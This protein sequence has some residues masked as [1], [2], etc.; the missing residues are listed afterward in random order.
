MEY[1]I[2]L[3]R[4]ESVGNSYWNYCTDANSDYIC[5]ET[6][7]AMNDW[8]GATGKELLNTTYLNSLDSTSKSMIGNA[9]YYLGGLGFESYDFQGMIK[10][11][12][13]TG[14]QLYSYE[15]KM[16][17]GSC[18]YD[19][20]AKGYLGT[21]CYYYGTNPNSWVGKIALMYS[22]DY[23]YASATCENKIMAEAYIKDNGNPDFKETSTK[24]IR[25]CNDTNW[26]YNLKVDEWYLPQFTSDPSLAVILASVGRFDSGNVSAD[27]LAARPVLYLTSNAQITGGSGT[28]TNPYTLGL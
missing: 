12:Q 25:A 22:S 17:N 3:I 16:Q 4:N 7:K 21:G 20:D 14:I 2:K 19:N 27:Q 28:S 1:R 24:D 11:M 8:T 9:K 18:S 26:L 5:D 6:N 13:T 15:R 23:F 10:A